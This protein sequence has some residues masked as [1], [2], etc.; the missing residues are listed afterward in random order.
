MSSFLLKTL[1]DFFQFFSFM[2]ACES[3]QTLH[4]D[5]FPLNYAVLCI[6]LWL[7]EFQGHISFREINQKTS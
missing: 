7:I 2:E 6:F 5:K 1:S 4:E 3:F